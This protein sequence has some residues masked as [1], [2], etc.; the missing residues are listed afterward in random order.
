M[1]ETKIIG[2][3]KT[4]T[5]F[6]EIFPEGHVPLKSAAPIV[7]ATGAPPC[8]TV[9]ASRLTDQQI[10]HLAVYLYAQKKDEFK[11]LDEAIACVKKGLPLQ[12]S[13]FTDPVSNQQ[14]T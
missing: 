9:D 11:N 10:R 12:V 4:D 5:P 2:F 13:Y 14:R 7:P 3:L 6:S 1:A 8:L